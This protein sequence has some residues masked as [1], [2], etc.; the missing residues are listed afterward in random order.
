MK[1]QEILYSHPPL[2][3]KKIWNELQ[4]MPGLNLNS[5]AVDIDDFHNYMEN[6]QYPVLYRNTF[7]ELFVEKALEHYTALK[8]LDYKDSGVSIDIASATSPYHAIISKFY[9][10]KSYR[11]DMIYPPGVNGYKIGGNATELPFED[12]SID[13]IT[14]HCSLEHFENNE[15][16]EFIAE[17]IR[18][19]TIGGK[20]FIAP[21]YL[22]EVYYNYT[23]PDL[24]ENNLKFDK[25]AKIYYVS[26]WNNR[27]GR[28]YDV[29]ALK[30][31]VLNYCKGADVKIFLIE[32]VK[33]VCD[34]CYLYFIF[35]L[36]KT[37]N[38]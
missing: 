25:N 15:D 4:M 17:A 8:L 12:N 20:L 5:Y 30:N 1:N 7:G 35:M 32:N 19:L 36:E 9:S 23:D 3:L 37:K 11:Q 22:S 13:W 18:K 21:L 6:A 14:L 29:N 31:R 26:G 33:E 10:C 28:T 2:D 27:F 34:K 24:N 16:S 38:F